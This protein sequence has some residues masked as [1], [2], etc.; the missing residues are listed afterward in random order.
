MVAR[1]RADCLQ[2]RRRRPRAPRHRPGHRGTAS[3]SK[4]FTA[5]HGIGPVWSPD[6]DSIVYQRCVVLARG[7]T[8]SWCG[9]MTS[10][11]KAHRARRSFRCSTPRPTPMASPRGTERDPVLG[12]LVARWR[13]TC[14]SPPGRPRSI[15]SSAW[16]PPSPAARRTSWSQTRTWP[17]IRSMTAGPFVPIQIWGSPRG[18]RDAF[19]CRADSDPSG[20]RWRAVPFGCRAPPPPPGGDRQRRAGHGHHRCAPLERGAER[21]RPLLARPRRPTAPT[22]RTARGIFAFE[23]REYHVYADACDWG[24]HQATPPPPRSTSSSTP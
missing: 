21:R 1:R 7:T 3:L 18:R 16:F 14:C 15:L 8:S 13:S 9:R 5:L 11:L 23:S 19:R 22:R 6:G 17:S 12:H 24:T 2:G 10:R 20:F 4:P